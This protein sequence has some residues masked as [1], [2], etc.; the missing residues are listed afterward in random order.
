VAPSIISANLHIV[1][2]L[3]TEGEVQVDGTIDGDVSIRSLTIGEHAKVCG[4]I[5]AQTIEIRGSID[6]KVKAK[7]VKLS[8]TAH[9]VGDIVHE[10]LS[11]ESGAYIEGQLK[12]ADAQPVVNKAKASFGTKEAEAKVPEAPI[13]E[14]KEPPKAAATA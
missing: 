12:R 3:K 1:G 10:I 11:V 7:E 13:K 9:V 2:N 4:E 6:G 5:I 14:A 8:K